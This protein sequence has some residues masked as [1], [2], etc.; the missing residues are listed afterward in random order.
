MPP[1]VYTQNVIALIWDFDKTLTHGYMQD[2]LF[3]HYGV[4]A[5]TFWDEVNGLQDYY[6]TIDCR[7]SADTVYVNHILTYVRQGKFPELTNK[8]LRELGAGIALAPGIPDFLHRSR[9]AVAEDKAF[10]KHEIKV[11][12]YVVSTGLKAMILGSGLASHID[13]VWACELLPAPAPP[14]YLDQLETVA[15]GPLEQIGYT[16]DNTSKT[17]AIFEINKGVN[18]QSAGSINVNSLIPLDQRRVPIHNMIYIADGPSDVPSFSVINSMGGKTLGV[19]APGARNYENAALLQDQGRVNSIAEANYD[20]G[21]SA[22]M[23]LLRATR[24]MAEQIVRNRESV[25]KGYGGA[26]GHV[27]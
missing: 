9:A 7:V 12:H 19:Y 24:Q 16:I 26:P 5:K 14:G 6:S 27:V 22:D 10:S 18:V 21:S 15:D 4:N 20:P 11:E 23:W 17:R 8:K 25:F 1:A 13:G 2:P 3:E